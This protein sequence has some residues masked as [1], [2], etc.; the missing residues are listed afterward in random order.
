MSTVS[1][2]GDMTVCRS[3]ESRDLRAVLKVPRD[4]S[5]FA[6]LWRAFFAQFF[7][8]ES[9]TSDDQ[10]RQTIIWVLAFVITPCLLLL[11]SV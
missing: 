2:P 3:R 6:V 9:V 1:V 8:S 7:T 5:P 10:L 4:G 11:I